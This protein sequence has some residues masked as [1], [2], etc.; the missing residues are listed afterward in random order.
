MIERQFNSLFLR[1]HSSVRNV[2]GQ[3]IITDVGG[4]RSKSRVE[5]KVSG[6]PELD[7]VFTD[8]DDAANNVCPVW[9]GHPMRAHLALQ[10]PSKITGKEGENHAAFAD[11]HRILNQRSTT[12]VSRPVSGFDKLTLQTRLRDIGQ[13][14]RGIHR[15]EA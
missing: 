8:R 7:I 12:F 4:V 3:C 11:T 14:A 6:A 10:D 5:F 13:P 15:G 9:P 1:T 2:I